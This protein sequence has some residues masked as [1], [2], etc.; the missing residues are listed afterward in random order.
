[1]KSIYI[2]PI[3]AI[4]FSVSGVYVLRS[5]YHPVYGLRYMPTMEELTNNDIVSACDK[6]DFHEL[7]IDGLLSAP[8]VHYRV[9]IFEDGSG[10]FE[11]TVMTYLEKEGLSKYDNDQSSLV[12]QEKLYKSLL[13]SLPD[14]DYQKWYE[15]SIS[16]EDIA[17]IIR[18]FADDELLT[19][20]K[21]ESSGHGMNFFFDIYLNGKARHFRGWMFEPMLPET[22]QEHN[23]KLRSILDQTIIPMIRS[24]AVEIT[25]HDYAVR[26]RE[27]FAQR[28]GKMSYVT[29]SYY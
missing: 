5:D 16:K 1:M 7:L 4:L 20:D 2:I 28:V 15:F 6:G 9:H 25:Q 13:D 14:G 18:N 19:E 21:Q 17:E 22:L 12:W 23:V 3:I 8:G 10:L 29:V 24:V 11:E 27:L 26:Q